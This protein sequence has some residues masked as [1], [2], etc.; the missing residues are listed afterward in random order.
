MITSI[1]YGLRKCVVGIIRISY[2]LFTNFVRYCCLASSSKKL[3]RVH[4]RMIDGVLHG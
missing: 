4:D 3:S 2:T 1:Y